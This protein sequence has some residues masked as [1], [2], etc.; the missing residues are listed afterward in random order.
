MV[1]RKMLVNQTTMYFIACIDSLLSFFINAQLRSSKKDVMPPVIAP[2]N[3]ESKYQNPKS[4]VNNTNTRK[5]TDVAIAAT[6]LY[7]K[8]ELNELNLKFILNDLEI[9]KNLK[10]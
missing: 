1:L 2:M 3:A 6:I 4:S 9:N 5:S 7:L 8:K 10:N